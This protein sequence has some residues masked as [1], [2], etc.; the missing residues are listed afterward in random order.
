V[1]TPFLRQTRERELATPLSFIR[2]TSAVRF[3]PAALL[4]AIVQTGSGILGFDTRS[5]ISLVFMARVPVGNSGAM[6]SI[7]SGDIPPIEALRTARRGDANE[8]HGCIFHCRNLRFRCPELNS[9][10]ANGSGHAR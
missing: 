8:E 5:V 1:N 3:H 7:F 10:G 4:H 2:G 9:S 6:V